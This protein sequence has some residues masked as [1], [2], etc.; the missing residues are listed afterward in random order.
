[1]QLG[2][3]GLGRMGGDMVRRLIRGGHNCVV[4]DKS[5]KP[6]EELTKEKA[7]G[8]T[9][10][11]DLVERLKTPRAVWLMLPAAVVDQTIEDLQPYLAS[12]DILIDGGNSYYVD[13]IRRAKELAFKGIHCGFTGFNLF[14]SRSKLAQFTWVNCQIYK[15]LRCVRGH[16]RNSLTLAQR[17][18]GSRSI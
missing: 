5:P 7:T 15:F 13:D 12:G 2:M 9:T 17:R 6:V 8:A 14:Q 10:L 18:S 16:L 3:I 11:H 4:F 1:M